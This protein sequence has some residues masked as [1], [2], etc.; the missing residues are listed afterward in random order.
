M[1]NKKKKRKK[2]K[3]GSKVYFFN[4]GGAEVK[5]FPVQS[6]LSEEGGVQIRRFFRAG[7]EYLLDLAAKRERKGDTANNP[8]SAPFGK[9][10]DGK[11][12]S[13]LPRPKKNHQT[14]P[15]TKK[16]LSL[17][18]IGKKKKEKTPPAATKRNRPACPHSRQRVDGKKTGKSKDDMAGAAEGKGEGFASFLLRDENR[19]EACG[20]KGTGRCRFAKNG[21]RLIYCDGSGGGRGRRE[22]NSLWGE[23][24]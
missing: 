20:A 18:H 16:I 11:L 1:T 13:R 21:N 19:T 5:S 2:E 22:A 3:K 9:K 7:G 4:N 23:T 8:P 17:H 6:F 10:R 12:A 14:P 24:S 15:K